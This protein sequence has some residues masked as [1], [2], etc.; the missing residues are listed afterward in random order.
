MERKQA[1]S[2]GVYCI[3]RQSG[4]LRHKASSRPGWGLGVQVNSRS[5]LP[6]YGDYPKRKSG[7]SLASNVGGLG[8]KS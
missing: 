4:R 7:R 8:F 3:P 1:R 6:I 2:G 5:I